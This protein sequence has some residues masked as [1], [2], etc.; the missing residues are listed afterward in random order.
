MI[1][2]K[3]SGIALLFGWFAFLFYEMYKDTRR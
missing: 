1:F 3:Y 2:L